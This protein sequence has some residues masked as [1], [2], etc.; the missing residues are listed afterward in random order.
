M[1]YKRDVIRELEERLGA[2]GTPELAASLF[3]VLRA[4]G[5]IRFDAA[6]GYRLELPDWNDGGAAWNALLDEAEER[7]L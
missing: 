5:Y 1:K 3:A 4:R 2:E 6:A 7:A